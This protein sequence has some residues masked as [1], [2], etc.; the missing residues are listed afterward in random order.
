MSHA[1]YSSYPDG[2][3]HEVDIFAYDSLVELFETSA[4]NT[5]QAPA[6]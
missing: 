5:R 1:W 4:I 2:I 3:P 6:F